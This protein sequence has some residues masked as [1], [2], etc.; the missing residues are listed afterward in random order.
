M[1]LGNKR[2]T[3]VDW[4]RGGAHPA[5]FGCADTTEDFFRKISKGDMF[6]YIDQPSSLCFLFTRKF[7]PSPLEPFLYLTSKSLASDGGGS[8]C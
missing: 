8:T 2:V 3:Y 7:A 1:L 6:I 5:A 4:L